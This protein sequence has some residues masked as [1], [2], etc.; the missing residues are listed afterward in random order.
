MTYY[1]LKAMELVGLVWDVR[2]VPEYVREGKPKQ[3]VVAELAS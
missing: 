3:E 2:D 1:G